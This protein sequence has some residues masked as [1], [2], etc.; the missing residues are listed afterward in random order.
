MQYERLVRI[1]NPVLKELDAFH[2]SLYILYH[3]YL[4]ENSLQEIVSSVKE[5]KGN[6]ALLDKV[7]LP[8]RLRNRET[9]FMEARANLARSVS[10]LDETM[11]RTDPTQF[12]LQVESMHGDYQVLEKVFE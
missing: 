9:A 8:E 12:A 1:T 2:Q 7:S 11:A 5:L 3:H 10:E 4:P 6:M